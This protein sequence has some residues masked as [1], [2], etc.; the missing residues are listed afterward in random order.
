MC[1]AQLKFTPLR[2]RT[3]VGVA[4]QALLSDAL[5]EMRSIFAVQRRFIEHN[6][7]SVYLQKMT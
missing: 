1:D 4:Q 7:E 5:N 6:C 2:S 3:A